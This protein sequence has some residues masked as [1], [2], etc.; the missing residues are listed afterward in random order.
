MSHVRPVGAQ[1]AVA[2]REED[3]ETGPRVVVHSEL[4]VPLSS[5]TRRCEDQ[6]RDLPR[7]RHQ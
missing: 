1:T 7:M 2:A 6:I 4:P 3:I 5:V